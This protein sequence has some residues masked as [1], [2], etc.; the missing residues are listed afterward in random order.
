MP[1]APRE[2]GTLSATLH[3]GYC[4]AEEATRYGGTA[5]CPQVSALPGGDI[6]LRSLLDGAGAPGKTPELTFT[7]A[8]V[9]AAMAY[10]KNSA[11]HDAGAALG[12]GEGLTTTGREYQGLLTQYR[13]IQSAASQPQL[14]M[15]AAS[16]PNPATREALAE[17]LQSPSAH[18][19]FSATASEAARRAGVM[20]EREYEAFE[21]GR[22][23]ANTAWGTDLQG[24][25]LLR[26][27]IRV[28][29]LGNW[30]QWGVKNE[31]HTAN[32]LTGQQLALAAKAQYAPQL[33]Q[34][35]VQMNE[36]V[37]VS[38]K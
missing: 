18:K 20:S 30:L 13:A 5:L 27:L 12:K 29:S 10:M 35:S 1:A 16:Q 25:N 23:Y 7:P 11:R 15:I 28:Q 8:P 19:Y 17:A 21:V 37:R 9:D 24:D 4:T 34:L 22:R 2:G 38:G 31:L 26:E 36:G 14:E 3:A 6:E 32:I 33:Q